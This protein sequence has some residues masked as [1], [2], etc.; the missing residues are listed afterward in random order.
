M[1]VE[2][3]SDI[4]PNGQILI[5]LIKAE[6]WID[7][8]KFFRDFDKE[9]VTVKELQKKELLLN[10][11]KDVKDFIVASEEDNIFNVDKWIQEYRDVWKGKRVGSMGAIEG[12]KEKMKEFLVKYPQYANKDLIIKAAKYYVNSVDD[13]RFLQQADYFIK[14]IEPSG[15]SERLATMCE[16]VS[17]KNINTELV[18]NDSS[19][20]DLL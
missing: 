18:D 20:R 2:L 8:R 14:K 5:Q 4:S 16:E 15:T 17:T 7:V 10:N 6:R 1:K 19:G 13:P 9:R 12:C 3:N 11:P